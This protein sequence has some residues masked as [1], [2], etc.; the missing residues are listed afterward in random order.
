MPQMVQK[1]EDAKCT[2]FTVSV[3]LK[4]GISTGI[5]ASDR[6]ATFRGRG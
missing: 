1:N 5:S 6:A 2:A 3:D 4:H